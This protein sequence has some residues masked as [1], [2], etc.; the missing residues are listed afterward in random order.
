MIADLH[1]GSAHVPL[2]KVAR[3]VERVNQ[4][5]PDL[6]AL[7]GDYADAR[8]EVDPLE[9]GAALGRL[10]APLGVVAVLGNHDWVVGGRAMAEALRRTGIVVLEND[11]LE[12]G[13]G[14]WVGGVADASRREPDL[15]ATFV[16]V[17]DGAPVVLLSHDPDVFPHV[18]RRVSLTLSGHTHGAQVNIPVV[19]EH[20]IPSRFGARYA[21]G[22]F[23][24]DGRILFVSR[25]VGTGRL[26]VRFLA[27]PE[28]ALL[29]LR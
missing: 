20:A 23:E 16:G 4:E 10:E 7:V 6:V 26:P 12:L 15:P 3:V 13:R 29:E 24:E 21:G 14:L 17:P 8:A 1:T 2:S 22:V 18:P 11:A 5:R 19:R 28:V 27:P 9:L 25:G